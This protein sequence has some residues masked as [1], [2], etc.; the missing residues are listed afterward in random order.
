M[1]AVSKTRSHKTQYDAYRHN[2]KSS[3]EKYKD[4]K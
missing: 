4:K 2:L 3:K 1:N